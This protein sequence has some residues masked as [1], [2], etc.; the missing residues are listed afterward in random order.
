METGCQTLNDVSR[1]LMWFGHGLNVSLYGVCVE[2]YF[3]LF[4]LRWG[5]TTLSRGTETYSLKRLS[6][7][8]FQ[9]SGA[10]T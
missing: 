4:F 5:I 6:Q 9:V 10:T 7:L 8:V 2:I 1:P 3:I